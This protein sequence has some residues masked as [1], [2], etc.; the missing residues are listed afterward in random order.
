LN[1][2]QELYSNLFGR[3]IN[4][5]YRRGAARNLARNAQRK[6]P[7]GDSRG[8]VSA[9]VSAGLL[10]QRSGV[11]LKLLDNPKPVRSENYK[12]PSKD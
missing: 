3:Y 8:R 12:S 11:I 6:S 1:G 5:N 2:G 9:S 10:Q 7:S 4:E